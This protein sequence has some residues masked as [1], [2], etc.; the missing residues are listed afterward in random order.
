MVRSISLTF[1]ETGT[2]NC[3]IVD[4]S[5]GNTE[6][7]IMD[8]P[9]FDDTR[10]SDT[11]ILQEIAEQLAAV[12]ILGYKLKGI[13]YLHQIIENRM[14][15]SALRRLD[16]FKKLI[17]E[18]ALA[19]VVLVTTMWGKVVT[20]EDIEEANN[21]D[22]ELREEYWG[23]MLRKGAS[24]TR[25]DGTTESAQGI[26]S[27][28]LGKEPVVLKVQKQLVDKKMA[29]NQTLAGAFLAPTVSDEA[30]QLRRRLKELESELQFERNSSKRLE[31]KRSQKRNS[32]ALQKADAD[33]ERL[34]SKPGEVVQ[35]RLGKWK[36][37]ASSVGLKSLQALAAICTISFGITGLILGSGL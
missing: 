11:E 7:R 18:E 5:I 30:E 29:L 28:L 20:P 13:V 12:R 15:G 31:A 37:E 2:Q 8:C 33:M 35:S 10:R 21:R 26:V 6:F 9:G 3:Q 22:S 36:K 4:T 14:K 25:F 32:A 27:Q 17:G 23:G 34:E 16:L 19:N 24:A 1:L